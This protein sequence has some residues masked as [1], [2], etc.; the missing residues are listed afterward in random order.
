MIAMVLL[1]VTVILISL[2]G[3]ST[4]AV[5]RVGDSAGWTIIGHPDYRKWASTK[6]FHVGDTLVFYYHKQYH[7]VM[8]VS[9]HDYIHCN[10]NS[11]KAFYHSGSDSITLTKPGNFYFICS[12]AGHCLAGQKLHIKVHHTRH[13]SSSDTDEAFP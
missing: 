4:S 6:R 12:N 7:D 9:H 13:P 11:A 2:S 8:E 3:V 10:I 5:Y 1:F